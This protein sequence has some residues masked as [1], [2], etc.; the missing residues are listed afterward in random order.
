M[1]R[2][3]HDIFLEFFLGNNIINS[4]YYRPW[5]SSVKL[6]PA[7]TNSRSCTFGISYLHGS[8][9]VVWISISPL[10]NSQWMVISSF[11]IIYVA[12]YPMKW[13]EKITVAYYTFSTFISLVSRNLMMK[14]AFALS[15]T[16]KK[17]KRHSTTITT[18]TPKLTLVQLCY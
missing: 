11:L 5:Q 18:P 1:V 8:E 7:P 14:R 13:R 4:C 9:W 3:N 12:H 16:T 17:S 10:G 6:T 2:E 15:L